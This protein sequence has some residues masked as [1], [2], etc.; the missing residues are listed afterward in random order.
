[1]KQNIL[2][3]IA[4]ALG[5]ILGAAVILSCLA[6]ERQADVNNFL[7]LKAPTT[8]NENADSQYYKSAFTEDG[9]VTEAGVQALIEA[10]D[11]FVITQEE[12][13]AVLLLN[14]DN[15]LP[16]SD[17]ERNVTLFGRSVADPIYKNRSGGPLTVGSPRL[18]S[19]HDAFVN[20]GFSINE[21]LFSAYENSGISRVKYGTDTV[22]K[23]T[24]STPATVGEVPVS[25]YT[26]ALQQTFEDYSD[27]AIVLF[28]REAGEGTDV[29]SNTVL[30]QEGAPQL[31]LQKEEADLLKLI[32]ASGKFKKTV[33]LINSG[34]MMDL[35]WVK[36]YDTY[37]VDACLYVG[38]MGTTGSV[39]IVNL[40]TGAAVPSGKLVDTAAMDSLSSPAMKNLGDYEWENLQYLID[41]RTDSSRNEKYMVYAEGIYVGY[42]YYETRYFDAMLGQYAATDKAG[43]TESHYEGGEIVN[44]YADTGIE[45]WDYGVEMAFPFGYGLSYTTFSQTFDSLSYDSATD[46]FTATVTV[47]NTGD[48]YAGKSVVE[49]Y[50]SV[51]Y[52]EYD[53]EQLV[54]KSAIQLVG[55]GKTQTLA[56]GAQ[57]EIVITVPR[58][59]LASYDTNGAKTYILEEGSYYFSIG[60]DAHNA[61]NN[62]LACQQEEGSVT[63]VNSLIDENGAA[64]SGNSAMVQ[65][66]TVDSFDAVTYSTGADGTPITNRFEGEAASD[67]NA[68]LPDTLTYLTRGGGGHNWATSFPET[69][70]LSVTDAMITLLDGYTYTTPE[71]AT[72]MSQVTL[73]QEADLKLVDMV[74]IDYDDPLW[75]TFVEQMNISELLAIVDDY[76]GFSEAV[77]KIGRNK[78]IRHSDGPNGLEMTYDLGEI[79][80]GTCYVS[81]TVSASSWNREILC[82]L[83]EMIGEE[84]LCS[85]VQMFWG[86]GLNIHRTPYSGRNFEY[87]SEDA[88]LTL[89]CAEAE[90]EGLSRKGVITG[91]KHLVCNDQEVNRNG[92]ATFMTEQTMRETYLRAFEGLKN[93]DNCKVVMCAEN[94]LGLT[95]TS[96]HEALMQGILRQEWG[97]EGIIISDAANDLDYMHPREGLAYGT[98]MWCLT[99]KYAIEIRKYLQSDANLIKCLQTSNKRAYYAY[100][101]SN[102]ING[103]TKEVEIADWTPWWQPVIL[104]AD[105]LLGVAFVTCTVLFIKNAYGKGK[106]QNEAVAE[107]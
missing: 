69:V 39:G 35:E 53:R 34:N 49:L 60:S 23:S 96:L 44:P 94:R 14:R 56:P 58:Y 3:G 90:T 45:G 15:A 78:I 37:G 72:D 4:G 106:K 43:R 12:E 38:Q 74:G 48:T 41:N 47:T 13:G 57:E 103:L 82:R 105:V 68:F 92:V 5:F 21:T 70:T 10:A 95:A 9:L 29:V 79:T 59:Y 66:Y 101:N 52:T 33:V 40:L 22:T 36:D 32:K 86:P 27:V 2:R 64:Q 81:E 107:N 76:K 97:Y 62:V 93:N 77:E 71:G 88:T 104:A 16:L 91:G 75:D 17:R 102:Y 30:T 85:G 42:K 55:F 50:A 20:A 83:G 11:D 31:S 100:V 7:G 87:F 26:D 51:P 67:I 89:L 98:D 84:C 46:T 8:A 73:G 6:F 25:F 80:D 24:S 19:F 65:V 63:L 61:V 99:K 28:S 18:V 1:M 54:E